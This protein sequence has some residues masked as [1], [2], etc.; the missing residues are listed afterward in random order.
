MPKIRNS[1]NTKK[2]GMD[3][4]RS[5]GIAP[6]WPDVDTGLF[7]KNAKRIS[8]K[9]GRERNAPTP[10]YSRSIVFEGISMLAASSAMGRNIAATLDPMIIK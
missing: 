10:V 6:S 8:P 5:F 1:P 9:K 7:F 2:M 4:N 3:K